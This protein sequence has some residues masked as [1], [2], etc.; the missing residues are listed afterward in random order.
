MEGVCSSSVGS[1]EAQGG[2]EVLPMMFTGK[3]VVKFGDVME[4]VEG[5]GVEFWEVEKLSQLCPNTLAVLLCGMLNSGSVVVWGRMKGEGVQD[6][7]FYRG[8][9]STN[10]SLAGGRINKS[11]DA[12]WWG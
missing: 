2:E 8:F 7:S 3:E 10:Q 11:K 1:S 5:V 4:E 12:R 9:V 6:E